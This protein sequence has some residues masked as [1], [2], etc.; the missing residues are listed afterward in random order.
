MTCSRLL[1][2]FGLV[3]QRDVLGRAVVALEQ[4]DVVLLDAHG[5]LDDA[6]VRS[7]AIRSL[8][9]RSHSASLKLMPFSASSCARRLATR[10]ASVVMGRYSYACDWRILM[11]SRSSSASDWYADEPVGVRNELGDDRALRTDRDRLVAR[12]LALAHAASFLEGQQAVAV[13]LVLLTAGDC[14]RRASR[15]MRSLTESIE[16][17]EDADDAVLS[18]REGTGRMTG[19]GHF[20]LTVHTADVAYV[21]ARLIVRVA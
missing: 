5:L 1:W 10:S 2:M 21:F 12:W 3:D 19:K 15:R 14:A 17:V 6:L 18:S 13:V 16:L 11:N 9:K 20:G 4:L 8:K 7:P